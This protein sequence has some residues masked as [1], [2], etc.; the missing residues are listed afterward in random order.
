MTTTTKTSASEDKEVQ[1]KKQEEFMSGQKEG[2]QGPPNVIQQNK[3]SEINTK[4]IVRTRHN[5][6]KPYFSISRD[7]VNDTD[8]DMATLGLW[9]RCLAFPD[10]WEIRL[11]HL[12]KKFNS[13]TH[14]LRRCFKKLIELGYC[15]REYS[16]HILPSGKK[17]ISGRIYTVYEEKTISEGEEFKKSFLE[18]DFQREE[19]RIVENHLENP[20]DPSPLSP[21]SL[22]PTPPIIP[23]PISPSFKDKRISNT[24][25]PPAPQASRSANA[26][27]SADASEVC[28]HFLSKIREKKPDFKEPNKET[29]IK[30]FDRILRIDGRDKSTVKA[31][32]NW[33]S[34]N[35]FW[36]RNVLSPGK[37]REKF[38]RLELECKESLRKQIENQF[39]KPNQETFYATKQKYGQEW[40]KQ[41]DAIQVMSYGLKN[42]NTGYEVGWNLPPKTFE[43]VF[44][45]ML[46]GERNASY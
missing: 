38:D 34:T 25:V 18:C 37:L 7:S 14:Q 28:A 12:A 22:S 30:E 5:K 40:K 4:S 26:P 32:I 42:K 29:W 21:S 39:V 27:L 19:K 17:I 33:I 13:T 35:D 45:K 10:D 11:E 1:Q 24:K 9:V 3:E 46:M 36:F 44:K 6:E 20:R 23:S 8:M 15:S 16:Y 2:R 43:E 31:V 41:F